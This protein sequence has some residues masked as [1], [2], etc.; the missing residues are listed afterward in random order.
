MLVAVTG[1]RF[2]WSGTVR[3]WTVPLWR[4][5]HVIIAHEQRRRVRRAHVLG[6]VRSSGLS[7][8][9]QI[10]RNPAATP[11]YCEHEPGLAV[12]SGLFLHHTWRVSF[13]CAPPLC[14]LA[15]CPLLW[16]SGRDDSA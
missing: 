4:A 6:Q 1:T 3:L 7:G 14:G 2:H 9:E 10:H 16:P 15:A 13:F 11:V 8:H 12:L 5:G